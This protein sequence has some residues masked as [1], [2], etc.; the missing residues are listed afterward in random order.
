MVSLAA[1]IEPSSNAEH[2][3]RVYLWSLPLSTFL[4]TTIV[5]YGDSDAVADIKGWLL[6]STTIMA[7]STFHKAPTSHALDILSDILLAS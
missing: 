6:V 5:C 1:R 2:S 3:Y 7:T 4:F